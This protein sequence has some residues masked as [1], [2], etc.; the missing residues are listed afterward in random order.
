MAPSATAGSWGDST[1][2]V[3]LTTVSGPSSTLLAQTSASPCTW[4]LRVNCAAATCSWPVLPA[5]DALWAAMATAAALPLSMRV[6]CP[7][8]VTLSATLLPSRATFWPAARTEPATWEL[9]TVM[10]RPA[11][12][13]S[14]FASAPVK[15]AALPA[16]IMSLPRRRKAPSSS[17]CASMGLSSPSLASAL[18]GLQTKPHT[19]NA[20]QSTHRAAYCS[21]SVSPLRTWAEPAKASASPAPKASHGSAAQKKS[22]TASMFSSFRTLLVGA[23]PVSR[24]Q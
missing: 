10:E 7:A 20:K 23:S 18:P 11:A 3:P 1:V 15:V 14:F 6:F 5:K 19:D 4:P 12:R 2:R 22:I 9:L 8:R 21:G 16:Q 17:R 24:T 13:M